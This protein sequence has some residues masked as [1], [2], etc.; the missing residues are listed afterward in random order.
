VFVVQTVFTVALGLKVS[1]PSPPSVAKVAVSE[2]VQPNVSR[3]R[4]IL[5]VLFGEHMTASAFFSHAHTPDDA[6]NAFTFT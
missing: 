6:V 4:R 2:F 3:C 5:T 1:T